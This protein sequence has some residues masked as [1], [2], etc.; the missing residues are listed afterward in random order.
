ML[1]LLFYVAL[2]GALQKV[3]QMD[4]GI[5]IESMINILVFTVHIVHLPENKVDLSETKVGLFFLKKYKCL[6][7]NDNEMKYAYMQFTRQDCCGITDRVLKDTTLNR[8]QKNEG[9]NIK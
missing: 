1:P 4:S 6:Q 3:T 8:P 2:N 9:E 7:T 5:R